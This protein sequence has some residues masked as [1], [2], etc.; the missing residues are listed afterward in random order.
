MIK[1]DNCKNTITNKFKAELRVEDFIKSFCSFSCLDNWK[2]ENK[3]V[4]NNRKFLFE[5]VRY[6]T[7]KASLIID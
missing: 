7:K 1:C 2:K 3:E 5:V 4:I 6:P